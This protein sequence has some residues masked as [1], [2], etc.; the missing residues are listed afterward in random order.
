VQIPEPPLGTVGPCG[1]VNVRERDAR[2]RVG[3]F[4]L[5]EHCMS[6]EEAQ[7]EAGRCLRCDHYGYGIFRRGRT[8]AW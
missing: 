2:E 4:E 8:E 1:R 7:Q 6:R 3:D 5:I